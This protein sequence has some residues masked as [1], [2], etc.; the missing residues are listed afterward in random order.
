MSKGTCLPLRQGIL[1]LYVNPWIDMLMVQQG[2][3][4]LRH[5]LG[6]IISNSWMGAPTAR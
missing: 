6:A 4:S 3:R 1:E 5:G 2:Q